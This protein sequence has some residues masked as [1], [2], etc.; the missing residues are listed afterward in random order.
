[1]D[2]RRK[3]SLDAK[4]LTQTEYEAM[5]IAQ[6]YGC[7]ICG[8]ADLDRRLAVDHDHQTGENRKLLCYKCNLGLGL[9]MDSPA[10]L[11]KAASYLMDHG[12]KL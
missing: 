4:L 8:R 6:N 3:A 5:V 9:F 7:S 11:V 10:L 1:M 12:K 2:K